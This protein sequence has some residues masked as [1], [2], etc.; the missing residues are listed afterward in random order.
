MLKPG[1]DTELMIVPVAK[2]FACQEI[3]KLATTADLKSIFGIG[4]FDFDCHI[5]FGFGK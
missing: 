5:G 2:G 4:F 1:L 3:L